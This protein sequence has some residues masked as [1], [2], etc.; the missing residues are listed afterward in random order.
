M[1]IRVIRRDDADPVT[2]LYSS[3]SPGLANATPVR[4]RRR[5]AWTRRGPRRSYVRPSG[6]PRHERPVVLEPDRRPER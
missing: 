5:S 1:T 4:Y 6:I 3:V 2:E